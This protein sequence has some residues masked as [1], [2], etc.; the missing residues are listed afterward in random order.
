MT[1]SKLATH[2]QGELQVLKINGSTAKCHRN[3]RHDSYSHCLFIFLLSDVIISMFLDKLVKCQA[4]NQQRSPGLLFPETDLL[5]YFLIELK[6]TDTHTG[7]HRTETRYT[8]TVQW[9]DFDEFLKVSSLQWFLFKEW[10]PTIVHIEIMNQ[11][12][13]TPAIKI[14][15]RNSGCNVNNTKH[16]SPQAKYTFSLLQTVTYIKLLFFQLWSQMVGQIKI[17]TWK[18]SDTALWFHK[19]Q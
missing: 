1:C 15:N 4:T 19:Q 13:D 8:S 14:S 16:Q 6:Y 17:Q 10:N 18:C 3:R 5:R 9:H 11:I 7:I 12:L 2:L